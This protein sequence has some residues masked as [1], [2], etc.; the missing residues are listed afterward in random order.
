MTDTTERWGNSSRYEHYMGRWSRL[1]APEFLRWLDAPHGQRWLDVGCGTGALSRAIAECCAP[2][3]VVGLD[4]SE[5]FIGYARE[6][7]GSSRAR[8]C[9]GEAEALPFGAGAFDLVVSGLALNFVSDIER[10]AAETVSAVASGGRVGVYVW[11]YAEGM[12]WLRVFWDA[13]AA[14]STEPFQADEGQRFPICQPDALHALFTQAGLRNVATSAVESAAR[15]AGI[16]DYWLPFLT[17]GQAP[18]PRYLLSRSEAQ[19]DAIRAEVR[20]RLP[21]AED[22]SFTLAMRAWA[23]QGTR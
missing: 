16:D 14:V 2:G 7:V 4:P 18:A 12:E 19:R 20:R 23:A 9:A 21:F 6:Q 10:A 15:F 5:D 13:A 11:D 3:Q 22:G 17:G 1:I 8:F